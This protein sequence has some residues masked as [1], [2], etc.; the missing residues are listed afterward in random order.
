MFEGGR[1]GGDV[2]VARLARRMTTMWDRGAQG[3]VRGVWGL[4]WKDRCVAECGLP[5]GRS[6]DPS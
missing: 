6:L 5:C 3:L 4:V 1:E 2:V